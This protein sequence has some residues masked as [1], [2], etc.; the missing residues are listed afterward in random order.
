MKI[1]PIWKIILSKSVELLIAIALKA[2]TWHAS[3]R[4]LT[5]NSLPRGYPGQLFGLRRM[6]ELDSERRD[7]QFILVRA[8][9]RDRIIA[10]R[11][12]SVSL[13][14]GL[15]VLSCLSL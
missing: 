10:L 4:C 9:D 6:L 8:L 11:P 3:C 15:I 2:P 13:C 12:V 7:S 14:I 5:P 1:D